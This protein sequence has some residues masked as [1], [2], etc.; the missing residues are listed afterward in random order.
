M[1]TRAQL[2]KTALSLPGTTE[3]DTRSGEVAFAVRGTRFASVDTDNRVL[4]HLPAADSDEVIGV[5]PTAERLARDGVRVP[6]VDINGQQLNH[7]VR[8]AW[9]SRAPRALADQAAAADTAAPGRVGD[10]PRTIGRPATQALVGAGIDTLAA[11]A[12]VS[13]AELRAMHGVGPKAV[14]ILGEAL[15]ASG[16]SFKVP[17]DD[18]AFAEMVSS[19]PTPVAS[20]ARQAR[21]LIFDVLPPTVEVVWPRQGT[22]GYGTGPKKMTEQFTWLAAA[23]THL[24]FGFYYG[25]ELPDPDGLLSGSGKLMRH[26]KVRTSDELAAPALRALLER[27]TRHRVPPPRRAATP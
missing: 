1:T 18:S 10:L 9:L 11:L 3:D 25:A 21:A 23:S 24:V 13:E 27:A 7:W 20:L 8:R 15:A 17:V 26:V 12:E 14:R 16:R 19:W 6:L 5:H 22:A 4:L 2:R